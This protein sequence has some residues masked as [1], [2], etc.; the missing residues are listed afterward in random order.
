MAGAGP[1]GRRTVRNDAA[2]AAAGTVRAGDMF[3]PITSGAA[4]L[5]DVLRHQPAARY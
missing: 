4:S 1:K 5:Y 3:F 2:R